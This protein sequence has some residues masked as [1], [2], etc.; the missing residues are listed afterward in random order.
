MLTHNQLTNYRTVV[1]EVSGKTRHLYPEREEDDHQ[2]KMIEL[3]DDQVL[4]GKA[5]GG[6]VEELIQLAGQE[7]QYY[8]SLTDEE[9]S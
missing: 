4:S 3:L 6:H 5:T 7:P 1:H 8:L 9:Y 2:E